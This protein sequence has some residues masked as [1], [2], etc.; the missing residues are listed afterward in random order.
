[1]NTSYAGEIDLLLKKLVE[2][3]ILTEEEAKTVLDETR[4][5][6][7]NEI[8][9][10]KHPTL[11][12]WVQ[13][14][15][16]K[17]DVRLRYQGQRT[18]DSH[19]RHRGRIRFRFGATSRI[20]DQ[21]K[22]GF[23]LASGGD[24]PRSTNQTLQ[25]FFD[26]PDIRLDRAFMEYSPGDYLTLAGGKIKNPIWVPADLLWDGDINPE[27]AGANFHFKPFF[28]NAGWFILD[29]SSSDDS[30][31][32]MAFIQP[33]VKVKTSDSTYLKAAVT[34][35]F[36]SSV[37]D[38]DHSAGTNTRNA[39]GLLEYKYNSVAAAAEFGIK[40]PF[41]KAIEKLA[42]F[43]EGIYNPDP[44]SDEYG[45]LVGFKFGSA[46]VKEFGDWQFKYMYRRLERDAWLDTFPD[47]DFF[48][49]DTGVKG[50]EAILTFGLTKHVTFGLDY[51]FAQEIDDPE[52]E[53][54]LL[55]ADLVLKF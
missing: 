54:H 35:Y 5:E 19:T 14:T 41:G 18:E 45:W 13:N 39:D 3:K 9:K 37:E 27:G 15:K 25:N 31:P 4:K 36:F 33:G 49:G 23:R 50:H 21:F 30:D 53:Q 26:T 55:Q 32:W 20:T 47:S 42:F 48:D 8:K 38:P 1:M 7:K 46:K 52:L 17:G 12:K 40:E 44:D 29:E 43:G 11:P 22:V 16:F 10:G 2:K 28:L 24:D 6:V 34:G 51:Y